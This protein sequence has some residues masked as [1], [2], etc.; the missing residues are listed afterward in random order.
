[1]A[2]AGIP[3]H[4]HAIAGQRHRDHAGA[5]LRQHGVSGRDGRRERAQ[6]AHEHG[7][8]RELAQV[9]KRERDIYTQSRLKARRHDTARARSSTRAAGVT[10]DCEDC[11][12]V[13]SL[14]PRCE[15]TGGRALRLALSS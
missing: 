15:E 7:S 10:E 2:S 8:G 6:A 4:A 1:M 9:E 13:V 12:E 14:L 5:A 3:S 11:E